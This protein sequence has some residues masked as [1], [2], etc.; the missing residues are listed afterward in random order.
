MSQDLAVT[1]AE[2]GVRLDNLETWQEKQNGAL[3]QLAQDNKREHAD[4]GRKIDKVVWFAMSS[5]VGVLL[6]LFTGLVLIYLRR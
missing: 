5:S 4:L 3:Q 2:H 1:V 6:T